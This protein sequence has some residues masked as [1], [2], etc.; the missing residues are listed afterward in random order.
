[1][2]IHFRIFKIDKRESL[3][4][5]ALLCRVHLSKKLNVKGIFYVMELSCRL[6]VKLLSEFLIVARLKA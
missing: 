3:L 2:K 1:M 6:N 4:G 5:K